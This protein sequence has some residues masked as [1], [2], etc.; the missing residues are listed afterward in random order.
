MPILRWSTGVGTQFGGF[1]VL[2]PLTTYS[3]QNEQAWCKKTKK[4]Q[5][6]PL[7]LYAVDAE[8]NTLIVIL[9]AEA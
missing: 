4:K 6:I 7:M 5:T 8:D 2:A 3:W 1:F 9:L